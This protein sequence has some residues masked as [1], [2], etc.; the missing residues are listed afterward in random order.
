MTQLRF[1]GDISLLGGFALAL[2]LGGL[3]YWIYRGEMVRSG[4]AYGRLIPWLRSIAVGMIV[5]MLTG[6]TLQHR[7]REGKPGRLTF[8]I[9]DSSSMNLKDGTK[10]NRFTRAVEGLLHTDPDLLPTLADSYEVKVVRGSNRQTTEL[11]S[12]TLEKTTELPDSAAAWLPKVYGTSTELG[13]TLDH[14]QSTVVV[15]FS[16]GQVNHGA[17]LI[18]AAQRVPFGEKPVFTIGLGQVTA[19]PDL[20]ISAVEHPDRLFR[21][22]TFTGK[23][24]LRDSMPAGKTF[25]IQAWHR[26]FL[27]WEQ[28]LTTDGSQ[29]RSIAFSFPIEKLVE[30]S[31]EA[32]QKKK[33]T[34]NLEL[35][36]LPID[37]QFRIVDCPD[38]TNAMNNIRNVQ[39]WGD[40]HRSKVLLLDGRSRWESR[41]IKN[42]FERDDFWEINAVIAEPA[43]FIGGDARLPIGKK[44]GQ[45]PESREQLMEY[46]LV[47]VGE[48]SAGALTRD[49]QQWLVDFVSESGGGL[50]AIDGP[51]ESWSASELS[52]LASILPVSR[53]ASD[54]IYTEEM[55]SVHLTSAGRSL[56]AMNISDASDRE[57]G[58]AWKSLP[59][60]RWLAKTVAIPGSE[61]LASSSLDPNNTSN[62]RPVFATR[63]HGAG[64]VF[65]SASDETWR[66]RY[67]VA[68]KVHQ[69]FWNQIARWVMRTPYVV[70]GEFVSLDA[71]RMTYLPE[72]EIEIRC[73]LK[74]DDGTSLRK[75]NVEAIVER[76]GQRALVLNLTEDSHVLGVYRGIATKLP[77]GNYTVS[78]SASGIPRDALAVKTQFVIEEQESIE[79]N[80]QTVD[81]DTLRRVAELTGGKYIAENEIRSL[82]DELKPLSQGRI[83]QTETILWQSYYWFIP[84]VALL[85]IEWWLRKRAGLL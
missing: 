51:R 23:I 22:D 54:K 2:L 37:L 61:V 72:Q 69:R 85:S 58:S 57:D 46:D 77:P 48:L 43:E 80:E 17:S 76:D 44:S 50:I 40:L 66:W 73:R 19:P 42:V 39:I 55:T 28:R 25:R 35:A 9:D 34:R 56:A 31:E 38:D 3:C 26:D 78:L 14:D 47:I 49:Q 27:A 84:V 53:F 67:K 21:R 68:D 7:W 74:R 75:A 12:S 16:D 70:E 83:V 60:F 71:G 30:A 6:P 15:L 59:P 1:F 41:Y 45:F 63:L 18:E 20:A 65:Y 32:N 11:W 33:A 13:E 82:I 36:A 5:L 64:R 24:V 62:D 4:L 81:T 52:L 8:V 29:Q 79:M 10:E